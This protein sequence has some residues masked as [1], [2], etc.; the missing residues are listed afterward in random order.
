MKLKPCPFCGGEAEVER[1]GTSR[2]SC[3]IDC[4]N[5]GCRLESNEI[6]AGDAWNR[7]SLI[8]EPG[9]CIDA[10][11]SRFVAA[12]TKAWADV[13]DASDWVEEQR[14]NKPAT[15]GEC[16]EFGTPPCHPRVA[17][18]KACSEGRLR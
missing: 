2:Q 18:D 4:A 9:E 15:C 12:G 14:G 11:L 10:D 1:E 3:I 17:T 6:G 16:G 7:R 8:P 13:P 5:C